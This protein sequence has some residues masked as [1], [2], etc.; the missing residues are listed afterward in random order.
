MLQVLIASPRR[1]IFAF[2]MRVHYTISLLISTT[3]TSYSHQRIKVFYVCD[4]GQQKTLN[5][6]RPERDVRS[7]SS[8]RLLQ[9]VQA[10]AS[11]NRLFEDKFTSL[12][13]LNNI[14]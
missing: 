11:G 14:I 8:S 4:S 13:K 2:V 5:T 1:Q 10:C 12:K 7:G 9:V 6:K 3:S